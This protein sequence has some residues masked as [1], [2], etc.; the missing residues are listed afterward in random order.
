MTNQRRRSKL[1][2]RFET[3]LQ[4]FG[5]IYE[6]EVTKI[7]YTIPESYHVYTVDWTVLNGK[8]IETKGYLSDHAERRKYVL[9]KEQHPELDLRF[10]FD[11]PN[12]L[13]GGTKMS[14][15]KWADKYGFKWC[16]IKDTEQILN[17]IKE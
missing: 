11:N 10:V 15:A 3:I 1:E 2:E 14:H 16:S 17:W 12:K 6:Y 8:L 5:V 7:P 9:L 4:E 13:C